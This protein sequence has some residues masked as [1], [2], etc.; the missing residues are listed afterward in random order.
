[1]SA[2]EAPADEVFLNNFDNN[3]DDLALTAASTTCDDITTSTNH[4]LGILVMLKIKSPL[5]CSDMSMDMD[6]VMQEQPVHVVVKI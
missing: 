2:D 6:V 3:D 1:M 4:Y 5:I